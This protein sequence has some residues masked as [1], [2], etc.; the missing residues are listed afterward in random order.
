MSVFIVRQNENSKVCSPKHWLILLKGANWSER[1]TKVGNSCKKKNKKLL[2]NCFSCLLLANVQREQKDECLHCNP[3]EIW[4][5]SVFVFWHLAAIIIQSVLQEV[6]QWDRPT[7]LDWKRYKVTNSRGGK[8]Q[9]NR[10]KSLDVTWI[11][12]KAVQN[13]LCLINYISRLTI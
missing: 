11:C 13:F 6:Q 1:K 10:N 5:I 7:F 8:G 2:P 9:S 4:H 12:A 3:R